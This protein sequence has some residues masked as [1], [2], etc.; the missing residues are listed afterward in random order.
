MI[1]SSSINKHKFLI[2][3]IRSKINFSAMAVIRFTRPKKDY[4]FIKDFAN[5]LMMLTAD[6]LSDKKSLNSRIKSKKTFKSNKT[7]ATVILKEI[8]SKIWTSI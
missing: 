8:L 3:K 1:M 7:A 4:L 5:K 2:K 6:N